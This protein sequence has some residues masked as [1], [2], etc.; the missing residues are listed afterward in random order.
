MGILGCP[1]IE[2]K[3]SRP[4]PPVESPATPTEWEC[5]GG[6]RKEDLSLPNGGDGG[7]SNPHHSSVAVFGID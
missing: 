6:Q 5:D 3:R 4:H 1:P 2:V 7:G